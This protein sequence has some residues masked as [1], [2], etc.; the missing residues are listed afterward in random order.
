MN[1][2]LEIETKIKT[3]EYIIND[4]KQMRD[5]LKQYEKEEYISLTLKKQGGTK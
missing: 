3:Y 2:K 4:L 1:Y 5:I